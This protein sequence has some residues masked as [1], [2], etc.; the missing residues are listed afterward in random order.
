MTYSIY[1]KICSLK[2]ITIHR[3][4]F[5]SKMSHCEISIGA[6]GNCIEKKLIKHS[7]VI[8]TDASAYPWT[9]M[10][11]SHYTLATD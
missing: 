11:H 9:M 4:V 2:L 8:V 5:F 10:I 3:K 7:I 6:S 1:L